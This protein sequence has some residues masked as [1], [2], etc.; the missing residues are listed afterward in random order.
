MRT[1]L[2]VSGLLA[3][4]LI[5]GSARAYPTLTGPTGL[6]SVPDAVLAP[7]GFAVAADW[8]Q[9]NAGHGIPVRAVVGIPQLLEVGAMYETLSNSSGFDDAWGG[10]AKFTIGH[11]FG[12][13]T[14]VGAQFIRLEDQLGIRTEFL[15]AYLAWTTGLAGL[16]ESGLSLTLG[17]NFTRVDV[18]DLDLS[19]E[20]FRFFAGVNFALAEGFALVGEYQTEQEQLG[21][22]SPISSAAVRIGLGNNL[23]A[24]IGY[25]N[26][27]NLVGADEHNLFGGL[28]YRFGG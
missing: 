20:A 18:I 22:I 28:Q 21:D 3:L 7:G 26:A 4:L 11:W 17:T 23:T 1:R 8:Q 2:L 16:G 10:N 13:Q 6:V 24:Q 9:L 5:T 27:F 15:Q 19:E 14:A 12:G 25:T